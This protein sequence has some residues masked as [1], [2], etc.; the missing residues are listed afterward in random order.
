MVDEAKPFVTLEELKVD[1]VSAVWAGIDL[2]TMGRVLRAHLVVEHFMDQAL[3]AEGIDVERLKKGGVRVMFANKW[4]LLGKRGAMAVVSEGVNALNA[5]RNSFAHDPTHQLSMSETL[6]FY[7]SSNQFQTYLEAYCRAR[8]IDTPTAI[9]VVEAFAES[10]AMLLL[11]ITRTLAK[12]EAELRKL[13]EHQVKLDAQSELFAA[14]RGD[15][16]DVPPSSR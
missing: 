3:G 10:A 9:Q 7:D 6:K 15:A 2:D 11:L 8:S 16:D 4:K 1:D 12:A 13:A 5:I 14:M